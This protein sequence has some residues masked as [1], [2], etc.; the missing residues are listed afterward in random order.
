M[1]EAFTRG[2]SGTCS[3]GKRLSLESRDLGVSFD[4]VPDQLCGSGQEVYIVLV[5]VVDMYVPASV[6]SS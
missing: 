4:F 5:K 1:K 6:S 3:S 2:D